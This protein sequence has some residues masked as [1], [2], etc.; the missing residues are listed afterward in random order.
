MGTN[1]TKQVRLVDGVV[2]RGDLGAFVTP[3][4]A[5]LVPVAPWEVKRPRWKP[6]QQVRCLG[7][8]AGTDTATAVVSLE[9]REHQGLVFRLEVDRGGQLVGFSVR[10]LVF[11]GRR[12]ADGTVLHNGSMLDHEAVLDGSP[13]LT[14]TMLDRVPVGRLHAAAVSA[15]E[16]L[17]L[18]GAEPPDEPRRSRRSGIPDDELARF[19][20]DYASLCADG[21]AAPL[22]RVAE[23]WH[24]SYDGA[25]YR[26]RRAVEL[27][28][29]TKPRGRGTTGC[30]LT[31]RGRALAGE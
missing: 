30:R 8:E 24:L 28:L 14:A 4:D 27:G 23:A 29:L 21:R 26:R 15:L 11:L 19:A 10:P 16:V 25:Q 18:V 22:E 12:L 1:S 7:V 20:R 9:H 17:V 2:P 6:G 13:R 31:E 3:A 5:D